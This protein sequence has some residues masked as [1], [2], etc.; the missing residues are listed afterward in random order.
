MGTGFLV[1]RGGSGGG[2]NFKIVGDTVA[3]ATPKENMIWVNTSTKITS[4]IFSATEPEA[5]AEGENP[6]WILTGASST[7]EFN[8]LKKNGIQICPMSA[9]QYVGGAWMDVTAKSWQNGE[10]VDWL[11]YLYNEGDSCVDITG[12]WVANANMK[13]NGSANKPANVTFNATNITTKLGS[14][15]IANTV[16]KIDVTPYS[17]LN[18]YVDVQETAI[19]DVYGIIANYGDIYKDCVAC[20]INA[21]VT[22]LQTITV[23]LV[24]VEGEYYVACGSS[25][26]IRVIHK[27]WLA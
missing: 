21:Q 22:G 8:A 18:F 7:V 16:N 26:R 23:P 15:C 14:V 6:V 19:S 20:L 25:N 1:Q 10:W 11:V 9:K 5:P 24:G 4:Y 12:G 13:L 17:T 2:L 3:P 27:V